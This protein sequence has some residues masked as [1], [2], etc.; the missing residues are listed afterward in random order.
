MRPERE[1]EMLPVIVI[2][3]VAYSY[4][5]GTF[6]FPQN[7]AIGRRRSRVRITTDQKIQSLA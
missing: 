3:V 6:Y 4:D 7:H 2:V 1:E 5:L